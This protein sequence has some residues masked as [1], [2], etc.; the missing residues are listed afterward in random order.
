M[1]CGLVSY[2]QGRLRKAGARFRPG[3]P[4]PFGAIDPSGGNLLKMLVPGPPAGPPG[5]ESWMGPQESIF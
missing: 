2:L 5:I 4:Q 1:F 3:A